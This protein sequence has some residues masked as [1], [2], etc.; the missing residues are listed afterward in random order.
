MQFRATGA[1]AAARYYHSATL[2]ADGK[3]LVSGGDLQ[4]AWPPTNPQTAEVYDPA[5]GRWG[6][7]GATPV[8]EGHTATALADGRALLAGGSFG[9]TYLAAAALYRPAGVAP[10]PALP[11]TGGGRRTATPDEPWGAAVL[12]LG[13]LAAAAWSRRRAGPRAGESA[14][15]R[16]RR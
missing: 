16:G 5:A 8:G 6:D 11:N 9:P 13:G 1:L 14:R 3:V 15:M 12:L 10:L 7:A 2:L 4:G